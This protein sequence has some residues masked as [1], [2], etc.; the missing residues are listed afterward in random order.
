[1]NML[2][3]PQ[4]GNDNRNLMLAVVLSAAILIGFEL[5][6]PK[7]PSQPLGDEAQIQEALAQPEKVAAAAAPDQALAAQPALQAPV[8]PIR[9]SAFEGQI[10]SKGGRIDKLALPQF[11]RD[12]EDNMPVTLFTPTGKTAQFFDAGWLGHDGTHVPDTQTV[13]QV[14]SAASLTPGQPLT[15]SWQN[16]TGQIFARTYTLNEKTYLITVTDTV[17]NASARPLRLSHYA[18]IHHAGENADGEA[19]TMY[20]FFGPE[21]RLIRSDSGDVESIK[22]DYDDLR[23]ADVTRKAP[24]GWWG[25]SNQYFLAALSA[26]QTNQD[27]HF[28]F[29]HSRTGGQDFT[30]AV[31]QSPE[32]RIEPGQTFSRTLNLYAGPKHLRTLEAATDETETPLNLAVD[33]GWF[34]IIARPLFKVLLWIHDYVGNWGAAIILLTIGLK[35]LLFPLANKSYVAM[36]KIKKLQPQMEALKERLKDDQQQFTMEM[37]KLYKENKVNPASGCWPVLMQIPIFFAMYKMI[38]VSFEFRQAE[39]LLW[40]TDLSIMDPFYVLPLLM[41]ASMWLQMRLSPPPSDPIQAQVM[42]WMP[43]IFTVLFLWF[44]A[45]LVLYWLT[46]NVFSIAQQWWMMRRVGS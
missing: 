29:R 27:H 19:S 14:P 35:I 40:I 28:R 31:V 25:I 5:F 7:K 43:I 26:A 24:S 10:S 22:E 39:F 45:G 37:F 3:S 18:Q 8:L 38:L 33:Y 46:N 6:Y 23:T 4:N 44:P 32:L 34:D 11:V 30:S 9:A 20:N 2:P 21:G 15:L 41:G 1:M 17:T 13:W 12:Q 42:Q 36:A 16:T